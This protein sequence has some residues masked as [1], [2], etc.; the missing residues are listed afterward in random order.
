MTT[1]KQWLTV[2]EAAYVVGRHPRKVYA[3]IQNG[4]LKARKNEKGVYEVSA[5]DAQRVESVTKRGRP[6]GTA[7]RN[8][9]ASDSGQEE[10]R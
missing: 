8:R 1:M 2:Q 10:D 7:S 3:W 4:I 6:V 9:R 5:V